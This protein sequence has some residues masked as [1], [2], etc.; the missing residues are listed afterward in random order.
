MPAPRFARRCY[1]AT[2][3]ERSALLPPT[4]LSRDTCLRQTPEATYEVTAAGR[5]W[6]D[7]LDVDIDGPG[8]SRRPIARCCLDGT[9]V[10]FHLSGPLAVAFLDRMID[11]GCP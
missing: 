2:L 10:R 8:P 9:E 5:A 4:L 1:T 3:P 11:L 7:A 6:F